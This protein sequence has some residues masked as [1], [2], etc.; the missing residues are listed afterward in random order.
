[1]AATEKMAEIDL[2]KEMENGTVKSRTLMGMEIPYVEVNGYW[3]PAMSAPETEPDF[4]LTPWGEE[5]LAWLEENQELRKVNLLTSGTLADY[6]TNIQNEAEELMEITMAQ[7][8]KAEGVTEELKK[9][10][11]ME[12]VR[13]MESIQARAREIVRAEVIYQ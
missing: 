10:N 7:M 1:M 13:K 8:A 3:L 6:L 12:W 2:D 4:R 11:Q 9:Q 5:H